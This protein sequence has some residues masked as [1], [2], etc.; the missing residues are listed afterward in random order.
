MI[1][2]FQFKS[3]VLEL[4]EGEEGKPGSYNINNLLAR[5][6]N[7]EILWKI[8]ELLNNY[9]KEKNLKYFE[10][11]YFNII[12]IN[13]TTAYAIGFTNHCEIDLENKKIIRLVNN[14]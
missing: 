12:R 14:R 7:G 3:C 4:R 10:E 9:S 5:S 8:E 11:V 1:K 6:Y 13:D 2:K